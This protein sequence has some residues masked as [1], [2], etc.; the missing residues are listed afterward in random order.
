MNYPYIMGRDFVTVMTDGQTVIVLSDSPN[1]LLRQALQDKEW[2]KIP[3]LLIPKKSVGTFV[4]G[5][6]NDYNFT[7]DCATSVVGEHIM[8][9]PSEPVVDEQKNSR[10]VYEAGYDRGFD[11]GV[12]DA[13]NGESFNPESDLEDDIDT[14]WPGYRE[15]HIE[16]YNEG[17]NATIETIKKKNKYNA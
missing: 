17:Y 4:S 9:S 2:G 15:G 13:N 12:F 5:I 3:E 8:G 7:K 1:P 11:N 10:I 6:P 16:G 14:R